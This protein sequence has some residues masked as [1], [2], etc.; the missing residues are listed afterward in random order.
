MDVDITP[1]QSNE[2][3]PANPSEG[4]REIDETVSRSSLIVWDMSE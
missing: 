4:S 2:F 1:L 3:A